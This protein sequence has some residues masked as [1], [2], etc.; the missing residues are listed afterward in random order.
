MTKNEFKVLIHKYKI[1]VELDHVK[2]G[3][4]PDDMPLIEEELEKAY[5]NLLNA[6]DKIKG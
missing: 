5:Q 6:Y 1:S 4:H 2:G 3:G